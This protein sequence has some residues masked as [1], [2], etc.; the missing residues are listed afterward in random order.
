MLDARAVPPRSPCREAQALARRPQRPRLQRDAPLELPAA[1]GDRVAEGEDA[2]GQALKVFCVV[3]P[4]I[5]A[6]TR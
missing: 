2:R 3:M 5:V 1:V 6:I 4:L